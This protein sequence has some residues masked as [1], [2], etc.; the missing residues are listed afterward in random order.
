M[1]MISSSFT[2]LCNTSSEV[3]YLPLVTLIGAYMNRLFSA[4]VAVVATAA[5]SSKSF[6]S[7]G[8]CSSPSFLILTLK[9]VINVSPMYNT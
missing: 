7:L 2:Y 1:A 8:Y 5:M 4:V 6:S 9:I 3:L